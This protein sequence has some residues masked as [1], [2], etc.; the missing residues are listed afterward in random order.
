MARSMTADAVRLRMFLATALVLILLAGVAAA[1]FGLRY[2]HQYAISVNDTIARAATS[3]G[4]ISD[5]QQQ[6]A[7]YEKYSDVAALAQQIVA[8]SAGYSYQNDAYSDLLG[9]ANRAGVKIQQYSFTSASSTSSGTASA[10]PSASGVG[11]T[12]VTLTL[13]NPVNYKNFL[14]FLHYIE[15]NL[16]KMQVKSVSLSAANGGD[17]SV[18]TTGTIT[19]EV[20]TQ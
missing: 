10:A 2:L 8:Q 15:Q 1:I 4:G 3:S 7:E 13:S 16:T 19:V 5:T 14:N 12:D 20:Y 17:A 18:V 11:T 9:I 6:V